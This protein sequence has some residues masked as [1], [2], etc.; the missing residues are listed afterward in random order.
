MMQVLRRVDP[1]K[2]KATVMTVFCAFAV[3]ALITGAFDRLTDPRLPFDTVAQ[4]HPEITLLFQ[5]INT[6]LDV[7]CL[8]VLVGGLP[9]LFDVA[10]QA[11]VNHQRNIVLLLAAPLALL[12]LALAENIL[13]FGLLVPGGI[14]PSSAPPQNVVL[15][16]SGLVLLL[17]AGSACIVGPALAFTRSQINV[18]ILRF[19][20]A[21]AG[22]VVL[23]MLVTL[24]ATILWGLRILA[25]APQLFSNGAIALFP[26]SGGADLLIIVGLMGLTIGIAVAVLIRL[27]RPERASAAEESAG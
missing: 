17:L 4:V 13:V 23:A 27:S 25:D 19:A 10:R 18:R 26:P 3:F 14:T 9:I 16:I 7:A 21:L 20:F 6:G 2:G 24:V 12:V 5:V 8:A 15:T 22:I 1:L 11:I